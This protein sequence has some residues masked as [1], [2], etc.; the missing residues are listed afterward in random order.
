M[1][2]AS[3]PTVIIERPLSSCTC[4]LSYSRANAIRVC[5]SVLGETNCKARCKSNNMKKIIKT[6]LP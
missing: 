1:H 4:P 6:D 2:L 3:T 5:P